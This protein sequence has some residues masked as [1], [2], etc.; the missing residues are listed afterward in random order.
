[1]YFYL[2]LY[3]HSI[4]RH[5]HVEKVSHKINFLKHVYDLLDENLKRYQL[6]FSIKI[7]T[8]T[9]LYDFDPLKPHFCIVKLEFTGV[10]IIFRIS[11]Q[12]LDCG[13]P[14]EPPR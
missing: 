10:Y 13:Y 12:K 8:K 4:C 3:L 2:I 1:M 9:C 6:K 7:I 5:L 11:A 14:L